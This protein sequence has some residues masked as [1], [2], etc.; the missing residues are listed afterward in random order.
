M[1]DFCRQC[2]KDNFQIDGSDFANMCNV[3]QYPV[4]LCE[5]CGPIQVNNKGECVSSDCLKA[6]HNVPL[7]TGIEYLC[8]NTIDIP[9]T[10]V[11][12]EYGEWSHTMNSIQKINS[13]NDINQNPGDF[14]YLVSEGT[15]NKYLIK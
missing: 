12:V 7:D 11:E 6:G 9:D 5:G 1:A 13:L 8:T 4:V 14:I 3:G 2:I 10:W 15:Y